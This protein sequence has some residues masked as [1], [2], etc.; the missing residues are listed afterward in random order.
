MPTI[1]IVLV[2]GTGASGDDVFH[3]HGAGRGAVAFP[4]LPA[5]GVGVG[6]E[7][8]RAAG[9][10]QVVGIESVRAWPDG[11]DENRTGRRAVSL[12]DIKPAGEEQSAIHIGRLAETDALDKHSA[13]V[14][15]VTFP[16]AQGTAEI[17]EAVEACERI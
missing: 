8:E 16:Q 7:E 10:G 12:P 15:A 17:Q 13:S 3:H 14:S 2:E 6:G 1:L 5:V 11:L 4:Q 9:S